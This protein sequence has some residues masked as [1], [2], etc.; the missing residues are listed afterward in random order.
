[1]RECTGFVYLGL[2]TQ[3]LSL[4]FQLLKGEPDLLSP[5][6]LTAEAKDALN[7]VE[8]AISTRQV[9]RIEPDTAVTLFITVAHIQPMGTIGQWN[10]TW[11]DLLHV[12]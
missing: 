12:L 9:Y 6:H 5:R 11:T 1:A 7:L 10:V 3:Q 8:A 4:L 2:T